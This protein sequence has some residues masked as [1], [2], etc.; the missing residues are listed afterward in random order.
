MKADFFQAVT[1]VAEVMKFENWLRFYFVRDEEG[2]LYM[3]V[4]EQ[5]Q[6]RI[7]EKYPHLAPLVEEIK[8]SPVTYEQSLNTVCQ[9]VARSLDG[10]KYPM[11]TVSQ[12]FSAPEFQT[13]MHLFNLWTQAHEE[14]LDQGFLDFATWDEIFEKW[15]NSDE[16]RQMFKEQRSKE[17]TT[18]RCDNET[19]H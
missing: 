2:T 19:T 4:P 17:V 9:F 12:V 13:E 16:V 10:E 15:K 7:N 8:D 3:R 18:V 6:E 14:Q 1:D 5:A 11:G